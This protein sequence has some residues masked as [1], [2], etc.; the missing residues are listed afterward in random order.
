MSSI[1]IDAYYFNKIFI[2]PDYFNQNIMRWELY[3][4]CWTVKSKSEMISALTNIYNKASATPYGTNEINH[5][6]TQEIHGGTEN[7]DVLSNYVE[8]ISNVAMGQTY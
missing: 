7:A 8:H 1:V 4:A 2:Y 6:L 3:N 5:F